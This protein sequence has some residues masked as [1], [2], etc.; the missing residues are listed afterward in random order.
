M[1]RHFPA[2]LGTFYAQCYASGTYFVDVKWQQVL[3]DLCS[4]NADFRWFD[5]G[6]VTWTGEG[7]KGADANTERQSKILQH[8]V[9][10][11]FFHLFVFN[12]AELTMSAK[13]LHCGSQPVHQ[14]TA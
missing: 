13:M 6:S 10:H 9:P 11:F 1:L 2:P 7:Q 5:H 3:H 8:T 4:V 12:I 14:F